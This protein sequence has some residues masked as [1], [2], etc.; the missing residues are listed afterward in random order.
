MATKVMPLR[1][2]KPPLKPVRPWIQPPDT[3]KHKVKTGDTWITLGW[4]VGALVVTVY[5]IFCMTL[6]VLPPPA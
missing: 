5:L 4:F 2:E 6:Y 3:F 1:N